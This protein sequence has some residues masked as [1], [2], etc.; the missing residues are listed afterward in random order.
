MNPV[1]TDGRTLTCKCCGTFRHLVANCPDT[2]ENQPKVNVTEDEH[3]FLFTGYNKDE[4]AMLGMDARNCAVLDIA[5]SSTVCGK[6]WHDGYL[7]SF[8]KE[9]SDE[10][11]QAEGVKIFKFGGVSRLKSEGHTVFAGK[12]V[13]IKTDVV[14]SD[15][16]LLL[17]RMTMKQTGV[18][19][20][21]AEIFGQDVAL[22]LTSSGHYCIPIDKTEK[23]T[24]ETVCAVNLNA[25]GVNERYK[26]LLKLQRQFAHPFKRK[27]V[28]L[29]KDA[30]VWKD[31]YLEVLTR[32]E[33]SCMVCKSYIKTPPHP[34][35]VLP[36]AYEF[37][38]K[39][40]MD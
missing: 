12:Q 35:V 1:G 28:A 32:I 14:N 17:S 11:V 2:W 27:L 36:I 13:T 19:L 24:V 5:C 10:A 18:K 30:G 4:I 20:D 7:K 3:A 40:A 33:E 6:V 34:V 29:L 16:P 22:T 37:N 15:I 26:I 38:E 8:D 9:H 39:V 31:D 21:I 25:I 23:I